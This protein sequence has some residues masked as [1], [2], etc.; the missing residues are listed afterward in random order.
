MA[1]ATPETT[2]AAAPTG[3]AAATTT[4]STAPASTIPDAGDNC[5]AGEHIVEAGDIP[6]SVAKKYD[7]TL[8]ALQRG[9]RQQSG[10]QP[11]HP[12]PDDHHPRQGRLLI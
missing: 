8:D 12:G 5:G 7:V 1:A 10:L 11:V 2:V 9:E 6:I 4:E 3:E